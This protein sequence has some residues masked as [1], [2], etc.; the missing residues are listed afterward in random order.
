MTLPPLKK[1]FDNYP[2]GSREEVAVAVGGDI[3]ANIRKYDW[4]TCC[5]RLSLS[6]TLSGQP[7]EGFSRMVNPHME[8]R[9]V[10]ARKGGD[11]KWYIYSCYDLRV[12]LDNRFGKPRK[13]GS[14]ETSDLSDIQGVIMFAF[15]HVDIW[16]GAKVKY[17]KDFT[18]G[19]KTVSDIYIWPAP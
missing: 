13:F 9:K 17:N 14:Y 3:A 16:D 4:E 15:R 1:L 8:D 7:I 12:Y 10:R 6:L 11:K 19:T 2:D 18:N 5:I